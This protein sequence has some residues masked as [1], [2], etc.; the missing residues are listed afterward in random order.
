MGKVIKI[1][2]LI[3]MIFILNSTKEEIKKFNEKEWHGVDIEHYGREV[4]WK[5]KEFIFKAC[6]GEEIV[7]TVTGKHESGVLYVG[8]IIVAAGRRG[9]GIGKI[10]LARAEEFG[11]NEGAHK[12]HLITGKN[13]ESCKFYKACGYSQIAVL[14]CHHFKEDFVV[15]EKFL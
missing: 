9:E 6:D 13:W 12:S 10:L 4:D 3:D 15:F 8:D 7:G 5:E 1:Y 11:K 14:P 2:K